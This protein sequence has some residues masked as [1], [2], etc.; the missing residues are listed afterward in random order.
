MFIPNPTYGRFNS[1]SRKTPKK[2]GVECSYQTLH[3]VDLIQILTRHLRRVTKSLHAQTAISQ[4]TTQRPKRSNFEQ[5]SY[6]MALKIRPAE[7]FLL[8]VQPEL[9][10]ATQR[11]RW[12]DFENDLY[13]MAL[14]I[15]PAEN[16][17]WLLSYFGHITHKFIFLGGKTCCA[18]DCN[19]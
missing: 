2:N 5:D 18:F 16:L 15:A 8:N 14:K 9:R 1:N 3:T 7:K 11:P 12:H 13:K 19:T 10:Q 6:K 4:H 17:C